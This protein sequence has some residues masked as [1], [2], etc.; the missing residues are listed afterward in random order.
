MSFRD[1]EFVAPMGTDGVMRHQLLSYLS[2]QLWGQPP[3]DLDGCQL[4]LLRQRVRL[5][6]RAL[7]RKVGV[8]GVR[9]GV[10]RYVFTSSHRHGPGYQSRDTSDQ[11]AAGAR[12]SR[13]HADDKAGHRYDT[14]VSAKH[15]RPQPSEALGAVTF[16]V[17][18]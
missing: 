16:N 3:I 9:L 12:T 15:G 17:A 7:A 5:E 13:S 11:D 1:A 4:M 14:I 18:M 10:N 6:F 8:F 2:R